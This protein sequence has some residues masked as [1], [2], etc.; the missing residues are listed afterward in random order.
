MYLELERPEFSKFSPLTHFRKPKLQKHSREKEREKVI[1]NGL[2]KDI[3]I[4]GEEGINFC[5]EN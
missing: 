4:H 3:A 5:H 2:P 1:L